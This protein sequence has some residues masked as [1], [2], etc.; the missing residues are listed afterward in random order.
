MTTEEFRDCLVD[1]YQTEVFGEAF[2]EALLESFPDPDHAY[3]LGSLL[4]LET[5]TKARL[6][7]AILQLGG[8]VEELEQSREA[9]RELAKSISSGDWKEFVSALNSA[10]EPL[11]KRQR[12]VAETAPPP[13]RDLAESMRVHGESIQNFSEAELA[14]EQSRSIDEV[15]GQLKFP[16]QRP[17]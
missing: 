12:E 8:S 9:G 4:Q 3:K 7:P 17:Q 6:R 5:E 11:L 13:Y 1:Y 10:G 14:G 15:V 2:F 16:L